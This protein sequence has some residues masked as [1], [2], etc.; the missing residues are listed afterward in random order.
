MSS[1]VCPRCKSKNVHVYSLVAVTPELRC[2]DC[3][4][5]W[6]PLPEHFGDGL[7]GSHDRDGAILPSLEEEPLPKAWWDRIRYFVPLMIMILIALV[8]AYYVIN[9]WPP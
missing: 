6:T 9:Y 1:L 3:G 4:L 5:V 8:V 7:A 2:D